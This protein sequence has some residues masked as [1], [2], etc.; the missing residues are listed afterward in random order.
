MTFGKRVRGLREAREWTQS[1]L[2]KLADV[3]QPTLQKIETQ[4]RIPGLDIAAKIARALGVSLDELAGIE[5]LDTEVADVTHANEAEIR[6]ILQ[7]LSILE[8]R[9]MALER[10]KK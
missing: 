6:R 9:I 1:K 4:D 5:L 10:E 7:R 3:N 8:S 2:A